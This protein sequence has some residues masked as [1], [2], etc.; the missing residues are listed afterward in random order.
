MKNKYVTPVAKKLEFD[1]TQTVVAS[2]GHGD[3]G[4]G[5]STTDVGCNRVPGHDNAHD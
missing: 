5:V 2:G 1:Y 3:K 4:H